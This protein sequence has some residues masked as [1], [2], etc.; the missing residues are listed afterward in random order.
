MVTILRSGASAAGFAVLFQFLN[1]PRTLHAVEV[2]HGVSLNGRARTPDRDNRADDHHHDRK[3][4]THDRTLAT[5]SER[6]HS[7]KFPRI[8]AQAAT[9]S[10]HGVS[11][12]AASGGEVRFGGPLAG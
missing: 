12:L 3:G 2:G 10:T 11:C 5:A 7:G 4:A 8:T 1:I 6:C 9:D